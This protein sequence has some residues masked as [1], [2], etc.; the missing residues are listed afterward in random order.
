MATKSELKQQLLNNL[1]QKGADMKFQLK[2]GLKEIMVESK[3]GFQS[4]AGA[5]T[6]DELVN[7]FHKHFGDKVPSWLSDLPYVRDVEAAVVPALL[8]LVANFVDNKHTK[9]VE[10]V[11]L[12]ALRGKVHDVTKLVWK[13][14]R[15]LF[16][17]LS[18]LVQD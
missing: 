7:L 5:V 16:E 18:N 1:T 4:G 14:V 6:A 15:P 9:K 13:E 3:E 10:S 12:M 8:Y 11:C 17:E 2:N